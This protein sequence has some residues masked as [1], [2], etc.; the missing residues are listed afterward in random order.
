MLF[1]CSSFFL[2]KFFASVDGLQP[3]KSGFLSSLMGIGCECYGYKLRIV[4][5]SLGGAVA[6]M[7]GLRVRAHYLSG[8][9]GFIHI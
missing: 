5:H 7:L 9:P 8:T 4:G 6:T 3:N 1:Y 2:F